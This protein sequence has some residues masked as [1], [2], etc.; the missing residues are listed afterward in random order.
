MIRTIAGNPIYFHS[1]FIAS[2]RCL[3]PIKCRKYVRKKK[4]SNL[5]YWLIPNFVHGLNHFSAISVSLSLS[6]SLWSVQT[7]NKAQ[8]LF[9]KSIE[10]GRMWGFGGRYYWGRKERVERR[11]GGGG[12]IVVFAWMSSQEKHLKNY[13]QLYASL[14]WDSLVCHS[15]FLNMYRSSAKFGFGF[16]F[17]FNY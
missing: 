6:L 11:R 5:H 16:S 15:E 3:S 10:Q 17:L 4:K 12:I 13:V 8:L 9:G 14:G 7:K 2:L 1:C